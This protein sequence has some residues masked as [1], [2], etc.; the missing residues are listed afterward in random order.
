[1][2][3]LLL[4]SI[5]NFLLFNLGFSQTKAPKAIKPSLKIG[6]LK[7]APVSINSFPYTQDFSIY[8][9]IGWDVTSGDFSWQLDSYTATAEFFSF[10]DTCKMTLPEINFSALNKPTLEFSWSHLYDKLYPLDELKV[11]LSLDG[12]SW[13][14]LFQ[15]AG[16]NLDSND[17]ASS[18]VPGSF[19]VETIDLSA[20]A[21]LANVN[22]RFLG[23]SGNGN[24][25]YIDNLILKD[26]A[27]TSISEVYTPA[28][29][30]LSIYPNPTTGI[31]NID[32]TNFGTNPTVSI[33]NNGGVT[34]KEFNVNLFETN[35]IFSVNLEN[36]VKGIYYVR[37]KSE[38][39]CVAKPLIVR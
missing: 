8:P 32:L 31:F 29:A 27:A 20:Y 7:G 26:A 2:K 30:L 11:E 4:L 1:M 34:V 21:G 25:L 37:V 3:K 23:V 36:C 33:I 35:S 5:L 6:S 12:V 9:L 13:T 38:S 18:Q 10:V 22:I 39:N 28:N 24:N 15:K 16:S 14:P 19:L 17:G